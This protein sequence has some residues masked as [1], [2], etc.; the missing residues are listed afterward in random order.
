MHVFVFPKI[1]M[2]LILPHHIGDPQSLLCHAS[3]LEENIR[4][5][6]SNNSKGWNIHNNKQRIN[7]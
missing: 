3:S 7:E 6:C 2:F 5:A 1:L 4:F